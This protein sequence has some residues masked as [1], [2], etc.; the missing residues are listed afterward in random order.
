VVL[1]IGAFDGVHLGHQMLLARMREL[2]N[3]HQ[4]AAVIVSFF[5]PPK[6]HFGKQHY[7]ST[8]TEKLARFALHEPDAVVAIHFDQAYAQTDKQ[9][10]IDDIA[11]L[12]PRAI[13]AGED[14]RFGFQRQG[15]LNDLSHLTPKLEVFGM[16]Q[17]EG[18]AIKS[19]RIRALMQEG[20][21]EAAN[22]LL[23]YA[24]SVTGSVIRG[25]QRG[26]S[27]GFPTANLSTPEKKALPVG[28]FAAEVEHA[29]QNY[30]GMANVGLRP[31]FPADPPALEVHLFDFHDDIYGEQLTLTFKHY[32]R[33]Q[34]KFESLDDLK[35]QLAKD[36][37]AA[38]VLLG[39]VD[40]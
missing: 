35:T 22:R 2:A 33:S 36:R 10:F 24:Y 3:R 11:S 16:R 26:R 37:D 15:S 17:L 13:I 40:Y 7:L 9:L 27:I 29:G 19:S 5:P 20:K 28:V 25:D 23:G 8:L 1:C 14:F 6:V 30:R 4:A 34:R 31:S 12:E 38:R 39:Q 21:I 18:E 32:L